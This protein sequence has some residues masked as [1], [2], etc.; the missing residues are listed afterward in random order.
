MLHVR[1]IM[2]TSLLSTLEGLF[3]LS[4]FVC[5]AKREVSGFASFAMTSV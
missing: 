3:A 1:S 2:I 4:F 5:L